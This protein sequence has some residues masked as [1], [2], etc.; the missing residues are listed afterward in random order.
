V[1]ALLLW[2]ASFLYLTLTP[3]LPRF[4]SVDVDDYGSWGHVIG[5]MGVAAILYLLAI[6]WRGWSRVRAAVTVVLVV[7][8]LGV[9]IELA[10]AI[11]GDRD[12]SVSDACFDVLGAVLAVAVLA[13]LVRR[14]K[15]VTSIVV[16]LSMVFAGFTVVSAAFFTSDRPIGACETSVLARRPPATSP[17]SVTGTRTTRGLLA[18]YEPGSDSTTVENLRGHHAETDLHLSPTGVVVTDGALQFSG[19]LART[20]ASAAVLTDAIVEHDALTIE[21]WTRSDDLDQEGPTRIVTISDGV[22]T[23]QVNVHLGQERGALS[24]RLRADCGDFNTTAVPGVFTSRRR[25]AHLA[26]T[27]GDGVQR[28]YVQGRLVDARRFSGDLDGW[29]RSYPFALGNETT[30]NRPFA[31]EVASAAVYDR[32]LG[33]RE[34]AVAAAAGRP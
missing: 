10:Q 24:V 34:I 30:R 15:A 22:E 20:R 23:D 14:P 6:D 9:A 3:N 29:D 27:Y 12:A 18:S 21:V 16:A 4:G 33:P 5:S 8:S 13:V 25:W 2:A 28:V 26:V 17:P 19:G 31:G 1:V 11:I 32:A 7:S